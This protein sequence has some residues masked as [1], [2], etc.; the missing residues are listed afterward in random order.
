MTQLRIWMIGAAIA[1]LV[2]DA[3]THALVLAGPREGQARVLAQESTPTTVPTCTPTLLISLTPTATLGPGTP[4][5]T[6]TPLG[7]LVPNVYSI[8]LYGTPGD[9]DNNAQLVEAFAQQYG[10]AIRVATSWTPGFST[11]I[12]PTQLGL[13]DTL[14]T[15]PVITRPPYA[16][17]RAPAATGRE[18][19]A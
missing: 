16:V 19:D 10:L 5:V 13:L 11:T 8:D 15:C 3:T 4:T 18:Q 1:L 2:L 14:R 17:D 12:M 9:V 7:R 6:P